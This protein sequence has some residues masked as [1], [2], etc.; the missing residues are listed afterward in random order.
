MERATREE[1]ERGLI[2]QDRSWYPIWETFRFFRNK[3]DVQ[4]YG[5]SLIHEVDW[6]DPATSDKT[7]PPWDY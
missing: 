6:R 5:F 7:G 1:F 3:N 4:D 2:A